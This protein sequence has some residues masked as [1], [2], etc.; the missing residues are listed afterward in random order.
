[1]I[2]FNEF[3]KSFFNIEIYFL[4]HKSVQSEAWNDAQGEVPFAT[5]ILGSFES[6]STIVENRK[7]FKLSESQFNQIQK[8]FDMLEIFLKTNNYPTRPREYHDL[9]SHNEWK[10]IQEYALSLYKNILP[11]I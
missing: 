6:W 4:G 5:C 8:L 1:M 10:K 7:N 9:Q 11:N 2:N 3:L